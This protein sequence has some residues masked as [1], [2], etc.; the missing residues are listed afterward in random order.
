MCATRTLRAAAALLL[1]AIQ[2]ACA[3]HHG[4]RQ[5]TETTPRYRGLMPAFAFEPGKPKRENAEYKRQ[6]KPD[7]AWMWFYNHRVNENWVV[8]IAYREEALEHTKRY[9]QKRPKDVAA[10]VLCRP[11]RAGRCAVER[12]DHRPGGSSPERTDHLCGDGRRRRLEDD[13]PGTKLDKP[14]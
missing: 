8:P 4:G 13:Q 12:P 7:L 1:L 2:A 11:G 5:A 6:G 3:V 10:V 9:N 14:D